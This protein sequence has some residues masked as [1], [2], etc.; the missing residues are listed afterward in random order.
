MASTIVIQIPVNNF[1][2]TGIMVVGRSSEIK[3][4][5]DKFSAGNNLKQNKGWHN[6][7]WIIQEQS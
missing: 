3:T 4:T 1:S 5:F 7:I 6:N 2:I